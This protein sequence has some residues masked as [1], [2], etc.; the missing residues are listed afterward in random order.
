MLFVMPPPVPV[1][2]I[3]WVP[4]GAFLATVSV[5]CDV[6]EP[7]IDAGLKLPVTSV[8]IPVADNATGEANPPETERVTT[9]YPDCPRSREPAVGETEIVNVP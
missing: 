9:A 3:A 6:P 8:G 7:V 4:V 1:M 5:K 2:V